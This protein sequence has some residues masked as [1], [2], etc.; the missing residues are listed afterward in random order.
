MTDGQLV[1]LSWCQA[2][3]W[4]LWPVFYYHQTVASVLMW[5]ALSDERTG[6]PFTISAGPRQRSHSRVWVPGD[7]WPYFTASDLRLPQP[8]GP[9]PHIYIPQEQCG[10]VIPQ[11]TGFPFHRLLQLTGL[12]W[13]YSN[14]PPHGVDKNNR[15][16]YIYIVYSC[17]SLR[18]NSYRHQ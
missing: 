16:I 4:G 9:G 3:I 7:S 2:P 6:V 13:R 8:G 14:P 5:G 17:A 10:P 15:F 1:S 11:G 12:W 18:G